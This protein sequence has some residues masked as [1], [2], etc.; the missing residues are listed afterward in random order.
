[1]NTQPQITT[2]R[3]RWLYGTVGT[4]AGLTGMAGYWWSRR[5]PVAGKNNRSPIW[6]SSF[7]SLSGPPLQLREFAGKPLLLNFWATWCPPCIE[8]FPLLDDFY[9]QNRSNGWQVLG[10][11]VDQMQAVKT[12]L[13]HHSV[14]FPI[15]MAGL[16][17]IELSKTLGNLSG[18]L[19]FTI[20]FGSSGEVL[21]RKMGLVS[22]QDLHTW[23]Q[24]R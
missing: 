22:K 10:L 4:V 15:A 17:G 9:R 18:G 19:P 13:Q 16:A 20:V 8:E 24:L 14:T 5:E 1:M 11:A 2:T 3:R 23:S 7:A 6:D 21:H 12:F